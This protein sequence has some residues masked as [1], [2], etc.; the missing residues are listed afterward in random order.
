ME[1]Q[2][3][4]AIDEL[5][6][7]Q[8]GELSILRLADP[9]AGIS[10]SDAQNRKSDASVDGIDNPS[11]ASLNDDLFHYKVSRVVREDTGTDWAQELFSKLRFSYVEQVTKEK[12]LRAIVGEPPQIVEHQENVELEQEL[13]G[14]KA[15]L[16]AQKVAVAEMLQLLEAKSRQVADRMSCETFV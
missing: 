8:T 14:E 11:P 4:R 7:L 9:I 15:E 16:K 5:S 10:G 3:Q 1:S 13:A 12:F 6:R 2:Y